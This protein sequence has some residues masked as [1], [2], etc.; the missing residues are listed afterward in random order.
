[1]VKA[2]NWHAVT[3][4]Q[5]VEAVIK[6]NV[7]AVDW[8]ANFSDYEAMLKL[9]ERYKVIKS[10]SK[11]Q[12]R[13]FYDNLTMRILLIYNKKRQSCKDFATTLRLSYDVL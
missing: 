5:L 3:A 11:I 9:R 12:I 6:V 1:M 8:L 7:T 10:A 4:S 2:D 13:R